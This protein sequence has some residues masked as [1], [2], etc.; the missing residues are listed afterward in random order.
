MNSSLCYENERFK[1]LTTRRF[2][3]E[4]VLQDN[5]SSWQI[6]SSRESHTC[7]RSF[8][9][10]TAVCCKNDLISNCQEEGSRNCKVCGSCILM[11]TSMRRTIS[12][13]TA[14]RSLRSSSLNGA[15][16]I[17]L[18]QTLAKKG[19]ARSLKRLDYPQ[20]FTWP[21]L[22]K[23]T[24]FVWIEPCAIFNSSWMY[25]RPCKSYAWILEVYGSVTDFSV[26]VPLCK[27]RRCE[28]TP[29]YRRESIESL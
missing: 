9:D 18:W 19:L 6:Q 14:R 11:S 23:R 28:M 17:M 5:Y 27:W 4:I 13:P 26:D 16:W 29:S 21:L 25:S 8:L 24:W 12:R 22:D 7:S 3:Q 15:A 2:F 1:A 20:I 10:K